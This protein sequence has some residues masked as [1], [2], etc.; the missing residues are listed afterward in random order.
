MT[1]LTYAHA[2]IARLRSELERLR[3]HDIC[4]HGAEAGCCVSCSAAGR[5]CDPGEAL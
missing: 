1:I 4:K 3:E 2:L 5:F